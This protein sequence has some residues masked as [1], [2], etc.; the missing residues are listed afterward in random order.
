MTFRGNGQKQCPVTTITTQVGS[1]QRYKLWAV[2]QVTV[3]VRDR[4]IGSLAGH[5]TVVTRDLLGDRTVNLETRSL[6]PGEIHWAGSA[7]PA[8]GGKGAP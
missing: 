3:G 7:S 4:V 2:G 5:H 1:G 8:G 6:G